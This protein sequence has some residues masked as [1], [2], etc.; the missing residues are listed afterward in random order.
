MRLGD[1]I[2]ELR[3]RNPAAVVK[4]GFTTGHS[5]R[6]DYYN[7][8]FTPAESA[9]FGSMLEHALAVLDTTQEGWKG[10]D[11][12]MH[13]GVEAHIGEYGRSGELITSYTFLYWDA[14]AEVSS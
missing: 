4:H 8:A 1:L 9:S 14:I 3:K 12:V 7:V 2:E 11:F 5:D 6:G 10:G 13:A